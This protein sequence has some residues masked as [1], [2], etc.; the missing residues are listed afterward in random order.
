MEHD[1]HGMRAVQQ[2]LP[3]KEQHEKCLSVYRQYVIKS[4]HPNVH[5]LRHPVK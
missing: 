5:T 1:S 4:Y 3:L 2:G